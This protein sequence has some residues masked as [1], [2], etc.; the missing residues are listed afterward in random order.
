VTANDGALLTEDRK[1]LK[2]ELG[3]LDI[4][5][6]GKI[7]IGKTQPGAQ[8]K[9]ELD[10]FFNGISANFSTPLAYGGSS[11]S[12]SVWNELRLIPAG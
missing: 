4:S 8:I 9:D 2:T 10:A 6:K 1:A 3:K 7:G 5:V 12:Q 11:F